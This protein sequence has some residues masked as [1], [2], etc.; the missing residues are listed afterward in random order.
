M[1]KSSMAGSVF[2]DLERE[3]MSTAHPRR[4]HRGKEVDLKSE[5]MVRNSEKEEKRES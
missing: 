5:E 3:Q 2:P 4:S 1:P